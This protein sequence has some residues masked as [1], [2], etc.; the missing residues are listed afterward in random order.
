MKE[1]K[2]KKAGEMVQWTALA[3]HLEDSGSLPSP[4]QP[5][6]AACDCHSSPGINTILWPHWALRKV[7]HSHMQELTV[8]IHTMEKKNK[9]RAMYC[10]HGSSS[11]E[12]S[13][14]DH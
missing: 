4:A 10:M 8:H 14:K 9:P 12:D 1:G 3:V 11:A 13:R 5:N 6:R 7:V 2:K